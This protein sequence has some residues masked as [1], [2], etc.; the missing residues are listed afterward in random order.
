MQSQLSRQGHP[1]HWHASGRCSRQ[2]LSAQPPSSPS[3]RWQLGRREPAHP[4]QADAQEMFSFIID[5]TCE[6][7]NLKDIFSF[8]TTS[9]TECKRKNNNKDVNN[10]IIEEIK[11]NKEEKKENNLLLSLPIPIP[12]KKDVPCG[13]FF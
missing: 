10:E 13:C 12:K 11:R 1:L 6:S 3:R 8:M 9:T 2:C 7:L 4:R 5:E